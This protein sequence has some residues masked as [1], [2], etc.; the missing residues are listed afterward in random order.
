MQLEAS[1]DEDDGVTLEIESDMQLI[2]SVLCESDMHRKVADHS[3]VA[4]CEMEKKKERERRPTSHMAP[5][6]PQE[7]FGAAG[8][9]MTVHFLKKGYD[10]FHS[11]LGHNKLIL[12]TVD[13]VWSVLPLDHFSRPARAPFSLSCFPKLKPIVFF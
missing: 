11:G 7:L 3:H 12:T 2:L 13:C 10:K 6:V 4:E 5:A 1:P 8:V 9:E